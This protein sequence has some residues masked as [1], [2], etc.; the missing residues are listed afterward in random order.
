MDIVGFSFNKISIN[1][2]KKAEA[3][4]KINTNLEIKAIEKENADLFRGKEVFGFPFEFKV[5]YEPG[6]AEIIIEG[7]ILSVLE[8]NSAKNL[9]KEWKKKKIPDEIRI[10]LFNIILSKC[11]LKA[12][13][14]EDD[15]NLPFHL[16]LPR[17]KK[18]EQADNTSYTG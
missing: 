3:Q 2:K 1:R 11:N 10:P 5:N 8:P 18:S 12:L 16:P 13:Q 7:S 15:L 17:L 14:L 4:I 9:L 6:F